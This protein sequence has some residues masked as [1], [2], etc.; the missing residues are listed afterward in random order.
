MS[1]SAL[2]NYNLRKVMTDIVVV[3]LNLFRVMIPTLI[4]VKIATEFGLDTLLISLF[5]PMMDLMALPSSAAIVLV[6]TLLT[7][8]YTGLIVAASCQKWP[9]QTSR[10]A[11]SLRYL[12]LSLTACLL[13]HLFS[14]R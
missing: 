12:C 1:A 7:N 14:Q 9:G 6:T 13:R 4:I 2:T 8:P 11:L 10:K 3:S 5:S